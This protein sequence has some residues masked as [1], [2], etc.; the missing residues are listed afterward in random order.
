MMLR[1]ETGERKPMARKS[2]S[3]QAIRLARRTGISCQAIVKRTRRKKAIRLK[4]QVTF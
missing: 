3:L 1:K 4:T 2:N